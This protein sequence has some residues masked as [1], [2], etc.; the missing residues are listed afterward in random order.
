LSVLRSIITTSG[1]MSPGHRQEHID[2]PFGADA[3]RPDIH[4][5]F[6][7]TAAKPADFVHKAVHRGAERQQ[8][9]EFG[10]AQAGAAGLEER[11]GGGIGLRDAPGGRR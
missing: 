6:A 9:G 5:V 4:A 7:D 11:F 2:D 3:R 1:P 8:A 10:A